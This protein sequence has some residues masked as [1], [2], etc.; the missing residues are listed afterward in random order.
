MSWTKV[1]NTRWLPILTHILHRCIRTWREDRQAIYS[2]INKSLFILIFLF[3]LLLFSFYS[4][5]CTSTT[6]LYHIEISDL[7]A[8]AWM[9]FYL[10][11]FFIRYIT[12]MCGWLCLDQKWNKISQHLYLLKL[13]PFFI[14]NMYATCVLHKK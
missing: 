8:H 11:P 4:L 14:R 13:Q 5:I 2:F 7:F 3:L 9:Y 1:N 10:N 12:S 6:K